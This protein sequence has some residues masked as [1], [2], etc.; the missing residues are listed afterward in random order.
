MKKVLVILVVGVVLFG[1]SAQ[2]AEAQSANIAQKIIGTWVTHNNVTWVFNANGTLVVSGN[3]TTEYKY[4]VT[5]T[6][7]AIAGPR[8]FYG[9]DISISSDGKTIILSRLEDGTNSTTW[10][11]KK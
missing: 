9:F 6:K 1:I 5:D 4:G 8:D 2:R 3:Q 11:T 7:L 10:L